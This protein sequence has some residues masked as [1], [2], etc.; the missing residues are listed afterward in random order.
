MN[1]ALPTK[2]VSSI[3]YDGKSGDHFESGGG[4]TF[5]GALYVGTDRGVFKSTDGGQSWN[6]LS[7][8]SGVAAVA[9]DPADGR[10]IF[11]ADSRGAVFKSSDRGVTW[12][13]R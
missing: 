6:A 5:N 12:R 8:R 3:T 11:A 4:A 10:T 13:N 9:V 1:G 7:L 2:A